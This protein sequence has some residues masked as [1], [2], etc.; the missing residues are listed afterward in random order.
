MKCSVRAQQM[1]VREGADL[2]LVESCIQFIPEEKKVTFAYPYTKNVS[3]LQ[4]NYGQVVA[5]ESGMERRLHK[6]DRRAEYDKEMLG[7]LG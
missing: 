5:I 1:T 7:Y 3:K 4:D 2:A 6:M